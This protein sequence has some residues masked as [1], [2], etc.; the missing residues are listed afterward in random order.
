MSEQP[1]KPTV[2]LDQDQVI[3]GQKY[4]LVSFVSPEDVI[5]RKDVFIFNKF[6]THFSEEVTKM[7]S[8][9]ALKF[10]DS[11]SVLE[12]ISS[13]KER[14]AC[15]FNADDLAQEL[16]LFRGKQGEAL[17]NAYYEQNSFQTSMRGLK[18]RGNYET[19]DEAK[20][21]AALLNA[22]DKYFNIFVV[23]VGCWSPWDPNVDEIA[24]TEYRDSSLNNL[25]HKYKESCDLRDV[26]FENRKEEM[27]SHNVS[28]NDIKFE[29]VQEA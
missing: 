6:L 10:E 1:I 29:V 8:N 21:R 15:I 26:V 16:D 22:G 2:I 18:L 9:I 13:V 24:E 12:V 28:T 25:M 3:R 14:H 17:E 20:K 23:E 27:M 11:P 19:L 4:G 7:F 5:Q